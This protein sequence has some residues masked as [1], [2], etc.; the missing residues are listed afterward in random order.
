[1]PHKIMTIVL[2]SI[3]KFPL[4]ER[5]KTTALRQP[6]ELISFSRLIDESYE[7]SDK[8]LSYYYFPDSE[9]NKNY[10]MAEGFKTFQKTQEDHPS[11]AGFLSAIKAWEVINGKIQADIV[12]FRGLMTKLL[13]LQQNKKDYFDYNIVYFDGNIFLQEDHKLSV[14]KE[15]Q[16]KQDQLKFG[17][18]EEMIEKLTY[19]GYKFEALTTLNRP[20]ADSSRDEIEGRR[21]LQVNNIEQYLSVVKTGIGRTKVVLGG[22]VDCVFDYKPDGS[23]KKDPPLQHYVELKTTK[24]I[25][26]ARQATTFEKKLFKTWAQSFLLGIPKVIYG[27]RDENL[28][29][30][31]VEEFQTAEIPV[32]L[33]DSP[34]PQSNGPPLNCTDSL[35]WF[36]AVLA[37]LVLVVPQKSDTSKVYRLRYDG[38]LE[39][40]ELTD[41]ENQR[42]LDEEPLLSEEF[43]EWRT[44]RNN[45]PTEEK[46][47]K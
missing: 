46:K 37:W 17:Q 14:V 18:S 10:D 45:Q 29:L 42:V 20:W 34:F 11:L 25:S 23:D 22:E 4:T 16:Q 7:I 43:I 12:S 19:S 24:A 36:G 13:V 41:E 15:A 3:K 5:T 2:S 33:K 31:Q 47:E 26:N 38:N 6:K 30:K 9:I 1:M 32:Y 28:K 8:S 27:F 44:Q 40:G 39:F 35:K 21:K